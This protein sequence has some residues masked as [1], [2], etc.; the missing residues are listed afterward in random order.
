MIQ[1][2][3]LVNVLTQGKLH[4]LEK[5]TLS[6]H[7]VVYAKVS[8]C[9]AAPHYHLFMIFAVV[10]VLHVTINTTYKLQFLWPPCAADADIIFLSCFF[11]L[12]F[13]VFS[14][15]YLSGCRLDVYHTFRMQVWNVQHAARW[16]TGRKKSPKNSHLSTIAQLCRAAT[17]VCIDNRKKIC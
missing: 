13:L 8:M 10:D 1:L 5:V 12:S 17:K 2:Q 6:H 14:S 4:K 16:N 11:F 7:H 15:P 9:T 3:H